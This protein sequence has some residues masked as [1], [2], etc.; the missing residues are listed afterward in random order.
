MNTQQEY[1]KCER[2]ATDE[3][4]HRETPVLKKCEHLDSNRETDYD[5]Y[6]D[7]VDEENERREICGYCE[8]FL[9][10]EV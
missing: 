5:E 10:K 1:Y 3:C 2:F 8:M 7:T 4:P 6:S 9:Q